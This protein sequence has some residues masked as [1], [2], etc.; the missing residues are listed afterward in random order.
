MA[1][2]EIKD[3]TKWY[4]H[5]SGKLRDIFRKDKSFVKAVDGVNLSMDRG[6]ILGVIGESGCGKSTL[7]RMLTRLEDPTK[8]DVLVDGVSTAELIKKDPPEVPAHGADRVPKPLRYF[9]PAGHHS[10]DSFASP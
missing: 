2:I 5:K 3:A 6:E 1:Y 7:G 8:G 9:H 4:P 10:E